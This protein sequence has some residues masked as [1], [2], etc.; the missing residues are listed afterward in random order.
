MPPHLR[1]S[2]FT[3]P[4]GFT[5]AIPHRSKVL[6]YILYDGPVTRLRIGQEFSSQGERRGD[7][8]DAVNISRETGYRF[9][10]QG[11]TET[12]LRSSIS[13]LFVSAEILTDKQSACNIT[14]T[15]TEWDAA[16]TRHEKMAFCGGLETSRKGTVN[17]IFWPQNGSFLLL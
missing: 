17:S 7:E 4:A 2:I 10:D 5:E 16:S 15:L 1:Y 11:L 8:W 6:S 14:S 13:N 9:D 12:G 3:S